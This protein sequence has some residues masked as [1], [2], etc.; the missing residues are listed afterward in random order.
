MSTLYSTRKLVCKGFSVGQRWAI[1]VYYTI[2]GSRK[3]YVAENG[4]RVSFGEETS[5]HPCG[6]E[7][8]T[9]GPSSNDEQ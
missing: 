4:S 5:H 2:R 6:S 7:G 8:G 9:F 1:P 3:G